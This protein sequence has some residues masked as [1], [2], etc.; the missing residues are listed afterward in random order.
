[1]GRVELLPGGACRVLEAQPARE[2][3]A[4][5]GASVQLEEPRCPV[6][7]AEE[8][9]HDEAV[10]AQIGDQPPCGCLDLGVDRCRDARA[11]RALRTDP[12]QSAMRCGSEQLAVA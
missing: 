12:A 5:P 3:H 6:A 2:G 1:M 8:L 9:E 10:P 11:R 4:A 7:V